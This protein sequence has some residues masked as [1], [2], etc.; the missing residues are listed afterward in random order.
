[1]SAAPSV[2]T[3]TFKLAPSPRIGDLPEAV[4]KM[5]DDLKTAVLATTNAIAKI[6]PEQCSWDNLVHEMLL[7]P[8]IEP[9]GK[10]VARSYELIKGGVEP[11][12]I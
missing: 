6:P 7:N 1:M 2:P 3:L 8:L 5:D 9:D 10:V 12:Q 11:L 4:K